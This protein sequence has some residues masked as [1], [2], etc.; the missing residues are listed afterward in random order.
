MQVLRARAAPSPGLEA[1]VRASCKQLPGASAAPVLPPPKRTTLHLVSSAKGFAPS[2][3]A[4]TELDAWE[5]EAP[6]R[7]NGLTQVV[8][9]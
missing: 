6:E 8:P 3:A 1:K 7:F 2:A 5:S 4:K 9:E